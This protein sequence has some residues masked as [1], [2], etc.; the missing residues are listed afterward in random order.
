MA[1]G[2]NTRTRCV[3]HT[4]KS[5][6]QKTKWRVLGGAKAKRMLKEERSKNGGR[7]A[8]EKGKTSEGN[9]L[10]GHPASGD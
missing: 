6:K 5:K 7:C 10:P 2:E 8:T 1:R 4:G 3:K 9:R